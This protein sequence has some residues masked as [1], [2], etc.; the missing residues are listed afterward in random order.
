MT[1]SS[2]NANYDPA[3]DESGGGG[4]STEGDT[5]SELQ[6]RLTTKRVSIEVED[7]V[8]QEFFVVEGDMLLD[9]AELELYAAQ[10]EMLAT[11]RKIKEQRAAL[12]A[13]DVALQEDRSRLVGV[14]QGGKLVR[15]KP[16]LA[17]TYCVLKNTFTSDAQY[18][19]VKNNMKLATLDWEKVCGIKFEHKAEL[20]TSPTTT[21]SGVLFTVRLINA[22]GQFIAS[23]FFPNGPINRRRVLI[24]P[25]YFST[26][27]DKVGVLRHELGHALGFRHEH[28]RSGAPAACPDESLQDTLDLTKYDP[29]SVMHYFCGGVGSPT[30]SITDIDKTGAQKLYGLP[31]N[32]FT[33]FE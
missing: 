6:K 16:G 27:F 13:G 15:W 7:G 28:I 1:N 29:Q 25:S 19:L 21:P 11:E 32:S 3:K 2:E 18:Q 4:A 22:G 14:T 5:L 24:D 20:D 30:L 17:L 8:E 10:Q 33:E 9:E 12:G 26:S 23:A 31:L